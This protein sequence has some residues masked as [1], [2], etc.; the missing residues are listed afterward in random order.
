MSMNLSYSQSIIHPDQLGFGYHV[1][2]S[3]DELISIT[4]HNFYFST[5]KVDFNFSYSPP[6]SNGLKERIT[7]AGF[8][9]T[10]IKPNRKIYPTVHVSYT[11]I[12]Q[13]N[14]LGIS[15]SI[16]GEIVNSGVAKI[17]PEAGIIYIYSGVN[18]PLLGMQSNAC[19]SGDINFCVGEKPFLITVSPGFMI[20]SKSKQFIITA[21]F[22]IIP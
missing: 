6:E 20:A 18:R 8:S 19:I 22:S 14:S 16:A 4:N 9:Y 1:G 2:H 11:N 7:S 10:H 21:G 12:S 15:A 5:G 17:L 3:K 13:V